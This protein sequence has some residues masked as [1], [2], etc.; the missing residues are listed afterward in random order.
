MLA[1][2]RYL[3]AKQKD[4]FYA[5]NVAWCLGYITGFTGGY[6]YGI[7][8]ATTPDFGIL[9]PASEQKVQVLVTWLRMHPELLHLSPD[10]LT[11]AAF[12]EALPCPS[13]GAPKMQGRQSSTAP[14]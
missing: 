13:A 14:R 6:R 11:W 2:L 9:G 8:E 10:T 3:S 7:D 12:A 5:S 1:G 4:T